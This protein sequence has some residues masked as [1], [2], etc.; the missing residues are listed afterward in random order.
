MIFVSPFL[1]QQLVL[2]SGF[3]VEDKVKDEVEDEV[4]VE[5]EEE[6]EEEEEDKNA[7]SWLRCFQSK[8]IIHDQIV[9]NQ[10]KLMK[11]N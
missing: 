2:V 5:V 4:A 9:Q 1:A 6:E 11:I 7:C 10:S 3:D 8:Q